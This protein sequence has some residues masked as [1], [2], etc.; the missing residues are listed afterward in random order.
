MHNRIRGAARH[1]GSALSSV[2]TGLL[3]TGGL[4][5]V[6]YIVLSSPIADFLL[7]ELDPPSQRTLVLY[8]ADG[9][10]FARRGGCVAE[11]VTLS[12]VPPHFVEADHWRLP[13]SDG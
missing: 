11:P 13:Q 9:R 4:I 7:S 12:E 1:L 10:P 5:A 6:P 3:V 8:A 2:I